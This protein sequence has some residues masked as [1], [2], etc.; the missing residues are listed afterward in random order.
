LALV[1]GRSKEAYGTLDE[2]QDLFS[3]GSFPGILCPASYDDG[4]YMIRMTRVNTFRSV[5][6]ND[7][8][9]YG[10]VVPN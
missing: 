4:P 8:S 9:H 7:L 6:F 10:T 3:R 1:T 2:F 5:P